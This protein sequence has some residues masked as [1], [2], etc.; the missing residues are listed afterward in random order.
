M[1]G[2]DESQNIISGSIT[3]IGLVGI[4]LTKTSCVSGKKKKESDDSKKV[5]KKRS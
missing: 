4:A 1:K 2:D 5:I 3:I